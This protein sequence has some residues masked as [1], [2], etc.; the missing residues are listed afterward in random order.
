MRITIVTLFPEMFRGPLTESL[1]KRAQ[2][3]GLLEIR[4]VNPRD[5]AQD[6]HRTVDDRPYGGGPGMVLLPEPLFLALKKAG[7]TK[8]ARASKT[9]HVVLL[10][11][12]G[13]VFSQERAR[14]LSGKKNLVFV[15]GH[16]EGV[17]ERIMDWVHEEISIGDYVL[18]GGEIPAMALT[19]A[20]ARLLP[21]VVKE[22]GSVREDSFSDPKLLDHPHYTR[23]AVWRRKTVPP[24][25]LS[26]HHKDIQAWRRREAEKQTVLKRPD[27]AAR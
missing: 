5:F 7:V 18:T 12:Q 1:L 16:Y 19:D 15:C 2:A 8:K 9:P 27:L 6:T 25:L 22:E 17:D 26:G 10:S 11:P 24:V 4:F 20:V 3:K 14:D 13:R 21:G 23:P